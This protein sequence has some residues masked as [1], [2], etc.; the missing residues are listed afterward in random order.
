MINQPNLNLSNYQHFSNCYLSTPIVNLVNQCQQK[1]TKNRLKR[2]STCLGTPDPTTPSEPISNYFNDYFNEKYTSTS[3]DI[4]HELDIT[5]RKNS[6]R[7]H[8]SIML[9]T[10]TP[11]YDRCIS[12]GYYQNLSSNIVVDSRV[13]LLNYYKNFIKLFYD[14]MD[15]Y[16]IFMCLEY[17]SNRQDEYI[18]NNQ[19]HHNHH[20]HNHNHHHHHHHH[21]HSKHH[22]RHHNS[23]INNSLKENRLF[24]THSSSIGVYQSHGYH[25]SHKSHAEFTLEPLG[26]YLQ[27]LA[28]SPRTLK[29]ITRRQILSLLVQNDTSES[30]EAEGECGTG[31]TTLIA[32]Q[33]HQL[34]LPKKLKDFLLFIE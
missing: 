34:T 21:H 28:S 20:H 15:T 8:S 16:S 14:S 10:P 12:A 6:T 11:S 25:S 17:S 9:L 5:Q 29:S 7:S 30:G 13:L 19:S 1:Q 22:S 23:Q 32:N 33:I 24:D 26:E 4:A 31:R 18:H 3:T 2:S 27:H